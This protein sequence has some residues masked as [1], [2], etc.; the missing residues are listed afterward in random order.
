[1]RS[2]NEKILKI[3]NDLVTTDNGIYQIGCYYNYF[4]NQFFQMVYF[5]NEGFKKSMFNSI[6]ET[7]ESLIDLKMHQLYGFYWSEGERR[8]KFC[9]IE[10]EP[11]D[12]VQP[13]IAK[14]I[15]IE[16]D[17]LVFED[18]I[19]KDKM[20]SVQKLDHFCIG[21]TKGPSNFIHQVPE[22]DVK[23]WYSD[24]NSYKIKK[25]KEFLQIEY[26]KSN[27]FL[28]AKQAKIEKYMQEKNMKE[29]EIEK[30]ESKVLRI[31]K[32]KK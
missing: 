3:E 14:L 23:R 8:L 19:T 11:I 20:L 10:F 13:T 2:L 7:Y 15:G 9:P 6:G 12:Y 30:E 18:Y 28:R 29:N 1:M 26:N 27:N 5:Q 25:Y 4:F 17:H 22:E 32:Y 21:V 31:S 24:A 16:D